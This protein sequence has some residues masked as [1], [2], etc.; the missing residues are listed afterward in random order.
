M[1]RPWIYGL[2]LFSLSALSLCAAPIL[3]TASA[4]SVLAGSA[5]TNTGPSVLSGNLG[6][7]P[8]SSISGFLP[9]VANGTTYAGNA[10]AAQAEADALAAYNLL[11]SSVYTITQDLTG[12]DL[13][14]LKLTP[15]VYKFDTTAQ[16][17]G[18]LTLDLLGDP[19]SLFIFR[20]GTGLTTATNS[21]VLTINGT[22]CCN[23]YWLVGSSATLGTATAFQGNIIADQSITMVTA[24]SITN[25]S[26]LALNGAVT[27][28]TNNITNAICSTAGDVPEPAT[29]A[30]LGAG[31]FGLVL[32]R[33]TSRSGRLR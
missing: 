22:G 20:I 28:D 8:G 26:A 25:G 9:G 12:T 11:Q 13:G 6:V 2:L 18:I 19:N 27:L 5:V 14:D 17:T 30:L 10:V 7:S 1:R 32:L 15:G 24:A 16:L 21:S 23:V 31:L 4:F 33:R 29:L 3:G